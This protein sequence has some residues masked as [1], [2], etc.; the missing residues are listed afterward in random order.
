MAK[1]V[2]KTKNT[3]ANSAAPNSAATA[4][5]PLKGHPWLMAIS[6]AIFIAWLA[7]LSYVAWRTMH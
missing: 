3:P 4:T 2:E 1:K 6:G 5:Q 7:F